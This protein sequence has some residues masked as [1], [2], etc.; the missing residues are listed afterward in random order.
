MWNKL[1]AKQSREWQCPPFHTYSWGSKKWLSYRIF[2]SQLS[3]AT[4][5]YL[6]TARDPAFWGWESLI[7]HY[8]LK[9]DEGILKVVTFTDGLECPFWQC[10]TGASWTKCSAPAQQPG[11]QVREE[12][13]S[14]EE[15]V[16]ALCMVPQFTISPVQRER[17]K[18]P[19]PQWWDPSTLSREISWFPV[20]NLFWNEILSTLTVS[21]FNLCISLQIL[22][23]PF[24]FDT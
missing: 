18:N 23:S 20:L 7:L 8:E 22:K 15:R 11:R 4:A 6:L 14:D 12:S 9:W 24:C 17:E 16:V 21:C 2:R 10:S 5:V 1:Y 19:A 13:A 3:N